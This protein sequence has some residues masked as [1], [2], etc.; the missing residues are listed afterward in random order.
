MLRNRKITLRYLWTVS[1]NQFQTIRPLTSTSHFGF[2]LLLLPWGE[3]KGSQS[4]EP[5]LRGESTACTKNVRRLLFSSFACPSLWIHSPALPLPLHHPSSERACFPSNLQALCLTIALSCLL[6]FLG[7]PP[8]MT[9]TWAAGHTR[10]RLTTHGHTWPCALLFPPYPYPFILEHIRERR[11]L[12][13]A[14]TLTAH[15]IKLQCQLWKRKTEDCICA[16][17]TELLD[18]MPSPHPHPKAQ[19]LGKRSRGCWIC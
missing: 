2:S 17:G 15:K 13:I 3:N 4:R 9:H 1:D 5:T 12:K 6:P 19:V 14:F 16:Q 10:G 7:P 18:F 11:E 8:L